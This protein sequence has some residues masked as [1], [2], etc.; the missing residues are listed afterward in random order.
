MEIKVIKINAHSRELTINLS[1]DECLQDFQ[2]T[3]KKFSKKVRL[4]GFR[5]GKIPLKVLMNKFLPNIEA[6]FI[7]EGVNKFYIEALK[8]ENLIPVNKAN[9]EDVHFHY[10]EHFKFKATFQIEPEIVLPKMKKNCLK[11]Q[12]TEYI[13]DDIDIDNVIDEM[14]RSR[15]E[16]K[17]VEDG[18]EEG[19]YLIVDFQKLDN[20]GLPIIGEKLEKRFLQIGTDPFSGDNM[21]KLIGLKAG[22]KVQVDLPDLNDNSMTK[23]ELSIINVEEQVVPEVNQEFIKSVEPDAKDEASFRNIIMKKVNES[24][25]QR[26]EETFERTLADSMIE[27]VKPDF[28]PA[29]VDS[30]LDHL[31]QEAKEQQ[32]SQDLDENKIRD[33]YKAVAERNMKWYLIRK[34]IVS[35]QDNISVSRDDI[36]KEIQKLLER[37]PDHSKEIKQYYKKPSN[38]QRIE[39]DLIEKKVLNYLE[40]FAKIKDVKVHTKVLREE[41]E[42]ERSR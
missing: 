19:H 10:E 33:S 8:E 34:A 32:Q 18:A 20:S 24:Y 1:W 5:P 27:Y 17:T 2:Q 13:S 40:D 4:P 16:V 35:N 38:R 30:Y 37:S 7:E 25:A 3:V 22:D 28:A 36:D 15:A 21:K 12:K 39:D 42:N 11:V 31:I 26:S 29:M 41:A 9:I 23:Y 14:R 6:E